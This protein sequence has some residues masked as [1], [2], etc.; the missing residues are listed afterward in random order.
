MTKLK[1]YPTLPVCD[2]YAGSEKTISKSLA[3][4]IESGPVFDITLDFE[5][6][7]GLSCDTQQRQMISHFLNSDMNFF[8]RV[9]IRV[10]ALNTEEWKEDINAVI[11]RNGKLPAYINVPKVSNLESLLNLHSHITHRLATCNFT[12]SVPLH[13]MIEDSYGLLNLEQMLSTVSVECVS[14]GLLDYVASFQGAIPSHCIGSPSQFE[15]PL[16]H[17]AKQQIATVCHAHH[18][19]PS[20]SITIDIKNKNQAYED[21]KIAREQ[22][23]YRRMW[24]IHPEQINSI[25]KAFNECLDGDE[26]EVLTILKKAKAVRWVPIS[27]NGRMYDIASYRILISKLKKTFNKRDSIENDVWDLIG[28]WSRQVEKS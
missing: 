12:E 15:H 22:F 7:S 20:H 8:R 11:I 9:G 10:H 2:H 3:L 4:Q 26:N 24:S 19:I 21:A 28:S 16:L 23:G 25:L 1:P 17:Y 27:H 14:L 6:G 5:D 18:V 13:I